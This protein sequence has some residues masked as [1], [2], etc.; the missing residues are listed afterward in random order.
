MQFRFLPSTD[1]DADLQ[2][3]LRQAASGRDRAA[4]ERLHALVF[5]YY[6]GV[7]FTGYAAGGIRRRA[8]RLRLRHR[9]Q[10]TREP[11]I[12]DAPIRCQEPDLTWRDRMAAAADPA[13][14][15]R[16][17]RDIPTDPG[18]AWAV[19]R[20][21]PRQQQVV[22]LVVCGGSTEAEAGALLGTSQQNVNR[23]KLRALRRLHALL[24]GRG[25]HVA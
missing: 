4:L 1:G 8:R 16:H 18:L 20:L 23:V 19:S 24:H 11:L 12:L 5:D 15:E 22:F 13:L 9:R 17:L 2:G 10:E 25:S 21:T 14:P 3:A 6:A 7:L